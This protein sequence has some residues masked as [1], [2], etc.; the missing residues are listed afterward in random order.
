MPLLIFFGFGYHLNID[1][2]VRMSVLMTEMDTGFI[3][4][5][6]YREYII[7]RIVAKVE[8]SN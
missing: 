8:E 3:I 4:T 5:P 7:K 1:E 2:V 6:E